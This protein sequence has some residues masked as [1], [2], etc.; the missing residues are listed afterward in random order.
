M[1]QA[2]SAEQLFSSP[3]FWQQPED[4]QIKAV[5]AI[6][7]KF[8]SAP[9]E[10]QKLVLQKARQKFGSPAQPPSA[11][12]ASNVGAPKTQA[13][14]P[15]EK[16]IPGME[17]LG[18]L[19]GPPDI[20]LP[21]LSDQDRPLSLSTPLAKMIPGAA[22]AA[23][24][25]GKI[26]GEGPIRFARDIVSGHPSANPYDRF[27]RGMGEGLTELGLD[28]SSPANLAL[29]GATAA[30]GEIGT[31]GRL[32]KAM[33]ILR[34][35]AGGTL[36]A[37]A[38]ADVAKEAPE[39]YSLY[40]KGD[41]EGAGKATAR[42]LADLMVGY[43][44]GKAASKG[45]LKETPKAEPP[46]PTEAAETVT[47]NGKTVPVVERTNPKHAARVAEERA[48]SGTAKGGSRAAAAAEENPQSPEAIEKRIGDLQDQ[49]NDPAMSPKARADAEAE[50]RRLRGKHPDTTLDPAIAARRVTE[51]WEAARNRKS[52]EPPPEPVREP[53]GSAKARTSAAQER[54]KGPRQHVEGLGYRIAPEEIGELPP[55]KAPLLKPV[56][57]EK[58]IPEVPSQNQTASP[59]I[60]DG[61]HAGAG[62]AME[63]RQFTAE[64]LPGVPKGSRVIFREVSD[65]GTLIDIVDPSGRTTQATLPYRDSVKNM[66]SKGWIKAAKAPVSTFESN[67][68]SQ[69]P[70]PT[71]S[72]VEELR[73]D[74]RAQR[75]L[76]A[77]GQT[78]QPPAGAMKVM[79][80]QELGA[81]TLEQIIAESDKGPTPKMIAAP[82]DPSG[83]V[84]QEP[85]SIEQQLELAKQQ[86]PEVIQNFITRMQ[87][88]FLAKV[89]DEKLSDMSPEKRAAVLKA[90]QAMAD[91]LKP[92]QEL[93]P[94]AEAAAPPPETA[95]PA[96]AKVEPPAPPPQPTTPAPPKLSTPPPKSPPA[97]STAADK[98]SPLPKKKSAAAA[99]APPAASRPAGEPPKLSTPPPPAKTA[100][101]SP[102]PEA[103]GVADTVIHK[104]LKKIFKAADEDEVDRVKITLL[105]ASGQP[106]GDGDVFSV[107]L[108]P[109]MIAEHIADIPGV[110]GFRVEPQGIGF[111][112]EDARDTMFKTK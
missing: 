93:L 30:T 94:K 37:S 5:S 96:P 10:V 51:R 59:E 108:D 55:Q 111:G 71:R 83:A 67:T 40:K 87:A 107:S 104:T 92:F 53:E 84:P 91:Y 21:A 3:A 17:K 19:P 43:E 35:V 22:G 70:E 45:A 46:V 64:R 102:P 90:Y 56:S 12:P 100:K 95:A 86:P 20:T 29:L 13:T 36:A 15:T 42:A 73:A 32:W 41:L 24:I 8:K 99:P 44:S 80:P 68:P 85:K 106:M 33:N 112:P 52:P 18:A 14:K 50:I 101:P 89:G 105:D 48:K 110:A 28:M 62:S 23:D 11:A 49:L 72:P 60:P 27:S 2:Q 76:P 39:A 57:A 31:A 103:S 88:D 82:P 78:A 25:V 98:R 9:P 77:P 6:G 7:P 26:A 38:L 66:E 47:V 54:S 1:P 75:G 63:A 4:Q 61:T 109:A 16:P 81:H 97:T 74:T 69:P 65:K 34:R 79:S 58:S